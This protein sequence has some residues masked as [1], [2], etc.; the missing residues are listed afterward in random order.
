MVL[1]TYHRAP[2]TNNAASQRPQG[3]VFSPLLPAHF[4]EWPALNDHLGLAQEHRPPG[5]TSPF[6]FNRLRSH[7]PDVFSL[8]SN[9]E[10][11]FIMAILLHVCLNLSNTSFFLKKKT[12]PNA[13]SFSQKYFSPI[14]SQVPYE[15][16][17]NAKDDAGCKHRKYISTSEEKTSHSVTELDVTLL[18]P[19][20]FLTGR[21]DVRAIAQMRWPEDD[22]R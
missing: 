9:L 18:Y 2:S 4:R 3:T 21:W 1:N 12:K 16:P 13:C 7:R 5:Q 6:P 11:N 15:A 17:L 10:V 19:S 22:P 14:L 8:F 20:L